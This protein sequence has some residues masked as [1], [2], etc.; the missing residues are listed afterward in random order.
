VRVSFEIVLQR[1]TRAGA[2]GVVFCAA[3]GERIACDAGAIKP[4]DLDVLGAALATVAERMTTGHVRFRVHRD[5]VWWVVAAG[6]GTY[7]VVVAPLLW[8][9]WPVAIDDDVEAIRRLL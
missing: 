5:L 7:L 2:M 4:Y 3:D 9:H 1:L 6:E 8:R